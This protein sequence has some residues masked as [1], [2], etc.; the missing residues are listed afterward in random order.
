MDLKT[1]KTLVSY[2]TYLL[3]LHAPLAV[4]E[5]LRGAPLGFA[6]KEEVDADDPNWDVE[7]YQIHDGVCLF[8]LLTSSKSLIIDLPV[9]MGHWIS[10]GGV[11]VEINEMDRFCR[12]A[13]VQRLD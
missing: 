8:W 10:W 12:Q 3:G 11:G 4:R 9:G 6:F 1:A 5:A 7:S 13:C 2:N